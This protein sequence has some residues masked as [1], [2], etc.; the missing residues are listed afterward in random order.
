VL[1]ALAASAQSGV[2]RKSWAASRTPDGQPDLQGIWS[3]A[4]ITPLERPDD[5][6][7]KASFTP[8]EA[9]AYEKHVVDD[10]NRDHRPTNATADVAFAYN[11]AWWD[12]GTHVVRTLRT[13]LIVDPPDGKLPPMTQAGRE[14]AAAFAAQRQEHPADGPESRGLTERCILWGTAGPPMMPGAYN[15]NYQILQTP[16]YVVIAIE[17]IHDVRIIPLDNSPHLPPHIKEWMGDSRGHWEGQTLVVDTTNFT[18]KT[19]FRG[20]SENLH[21]TER[22]TRTA[23]DTILY[24]FTVD[25][26]SIYT[27][28][29]TAQI[30]MAQSHEHIYEYAC[31]E[32]NLGMTNILAGARAEEKK[33]TPQ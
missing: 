4:T 29:W 7:G 13:S 14:R 12:R 22:F 9:L 26:P 11:E 33:K 1:A 25:D 3:N 20:T 24:E 8:A 5:L 2:P 16:G 15:N 23:A 18:G 28:P 19:R 6:A 30:T 10:T 31:H 21:L 27:K 32:G 17:M